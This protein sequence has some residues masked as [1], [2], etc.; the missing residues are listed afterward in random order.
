MSY[1]ISLNRVQ[2]TQVYIIFKCDIND[3]PLTIDK[4]CCKVTM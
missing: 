2:L 4:E 1:E 3:T